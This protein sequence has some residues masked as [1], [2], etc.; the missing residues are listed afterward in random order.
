MRSHS[1]LGFLEIMGGEHDRHA[2]RVELA[3][4]VPQLPAK[5]DVDARGR[6]VEHQDRRRM[7]HRLGDQQPPLHSARQRAR[8]GVAPCRS[9]ASPRAARRCAGRR[10]AIPYSPAWI[11]SVSRGVKKGSKMISC[12]TTPIE[13]LALRGCWSMSKPQI[14]DLAAGLHH[15]PGEDV[16]QGRL[17]RAV[18]AEQAEDL[19][20][21]HVEADLVERQLGS[22]PCGGIG[23]RR[24]FDADRGLV[25][26][27]SRHRGGTSATSRR[28]ALKRGACGPYLA[29]MAS[30]PPPEV[31]R[32]SH[33]AGR[34]RRIG[35]DRARAR[36]SAR[37]SADRRGARLRRVRLLRPAFCP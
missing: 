33:L 31:I 6:L 9:G 37:L 12:G 32:V 20:A 4:I 16:D 24:G 8:I 34:L 11:S 3:D 21:R 10:G 13:R 15:Q 28:S 27:A 25:H 26:G 35:R 14:V 23:L 36:P 1:S 7:D 30:I 22:A 18:G 29:A 19:P 2:L 17:A 5:L